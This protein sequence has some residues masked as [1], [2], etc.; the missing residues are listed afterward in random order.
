MGWGVGRGKRGGGRRRGEGREI[1]IVEEQYVRKRRGGGGQ[2]RKVERLR[3]AG[4]MLC[5]RVVKLD[6]VI[7]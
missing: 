2:T 1:V 6:D 4:G 7:F 5:E 3:G